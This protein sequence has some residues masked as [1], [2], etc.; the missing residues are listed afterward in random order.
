MAFLLFYRVIFL[1]LSVLIL[2]VFLLWAVALKFFSSSNKLSR[3]LLLRWRAFH[4]L[5]LWSAFPAHQNVYWFHAASGE[6]EYAKPVMRELKRL[7]PQCKIVWSYSSVSALDFFSGVVDVDFKFPLPF[8]SIW[9]NK[10]LIRMIRPK[11]VLIARS[12]VWPELMHQLRYAKIP[13]VLFAAT[14]SERKSK[15]FFQSQIFSLLS[16]ISC[17]STEDLQHLQQMH[18]P[19]T[20]SQDGDPRADQVNYRAKNARETMDLKS[21][22]TQEKILVLGST[23]PEDENALQEVFKMPGWSFVLVPHDWSAEKRS[24][25]SILFAEKKLGFFSE[26]QTHPNDQRYDVIVVDQKGILADLYRQAT[27][28]FVGGSFK[29]KVHSVY[30]PLAWGKKVYVGPFHT[31]NREA[32][33]FSALSCEGEP[34]VTV[35]S[36]GLQMKASCESLQK[37]DFQKLNAP[38]TEI[39]QKKLG[40][41][42]RIAQ[43]MRK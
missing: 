33:E 8:D 5:R 40:A 22:L 38:I 24:A 12:D 37:N 19:A 35:I 3:T 21:M 34:F 23:W 28:V 13:R 15:S 7:D 6:I 29:D 20:I 36:N 9:N 26:L 11:A 32:M 42:A 4:E 10:K 41:S 27:T 18:L 30:E 1:L 31:N 14:V 43:R 2:P 17:V 39:I 25:Y 16:H